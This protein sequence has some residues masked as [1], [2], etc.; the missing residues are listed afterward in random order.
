MSRA[1]WDELNAQPLKP[2]R[3]GCAVSPRRPDRIIKPMLITEPTKRI[4][5]PELRKAIDEASDEL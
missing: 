3:W 4:T 5:Q 2:C 1:F